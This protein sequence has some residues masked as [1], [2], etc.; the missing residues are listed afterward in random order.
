[1]SCNL[2]VHADPTGGSKYISGTTCDGTTAYY[3]LTL[4]QSVCMNTTLPYENLCG[5][6]LSGSC[7]AVT[8]TP[9][10]TPLEYCI[11]SGLTY[12]TQPFE[13]PFDGTIYYDIYGKLRITAAIF[14]TITSTHPPLTAFISNGI[15]NVSLTIPENETFA[16][17]VYLKSNFEFSG[18]TCQN[19]VY[20]DWFIITGTTYTCLF[21]TPTPTPTLTQTPTQTSTQTQTPTQTSTETP[22]ETPTQTPTTTTTLTSTPTQT[23][24]Q[25]PTPTNTETPTPTTT[26]TTTLTSTPT[27]TQTPTNTFTPTQTQTPTQ[28]ST[29]TPTNTQTPTPTNT[30]TKT[31]TPT[32]TQ[33]PPTEGTNEARLYLEAVVQ[34][35]GTGITPTV[36]A[37]TITLFNQIFSNGLWNKIQAFYPM[38]GGNS[39]GTKFNAKNPLDTNA[40]YRLQFNGGW[41]FSSNGIISNGTTAYADTFLSGGTI[42]SLNNHMGVYLQNVNNAGSKTWIG[43]SAPGGT[44]SYFIMATDGTPRIFYGNKVNGGITTF[45]TT[46]GSQGFNI[47]TALQQ[48]N[49]QRYF[50]NGVIQ[51]SGSA[52]NTES[53]T[54]SVTIAALNNSGS[55]VQYYDN[56]YSY[57][58]IGSGLTDTE[59]INYTNI[60]NTFN[61]CL[62]RNVFPAVTQTPTPTPGLSPTQTPTPS[63]TPPVTPT[64]TRTPTRTPTP[65]ETPAVPGYYTA[66]F[67]YQCGGYGTQLVS[68]TYAIGKYYCVPKSAYRNPPQ[69][70]TGLVDMYK[71]IGTGAVNSNVIPIC[72]SD[73]SCQA[74]ANRGCF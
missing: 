18:G 59:A 68:G 43:A 44:G 2:F 15:E 55:I 56:T 39:N 26:P 16:D 40:A 66:Q 6:I 54:S 71:I 62:G 1:M 21:F 32:P 41:T 19:V 52:T 64:N 25:T 48:T 51:Y 11:V 23:E 33:T 29:Q 27:Q 65:T 72:D 38:L 37:C 36:S 8:P 57:V 47:I 60:V 69:C 3:T 22:T 73:W 67:Y 30:V 4:G 31:S 14:G 5:L 45:T 13:C 7:L 10:T 35:G 17:Y 34:A 9:T 63:S 50:R 61:E 58:T 70:G 53:I 42:G 24:T 12:S 49:G 46:T 28:T 20:P 74:L